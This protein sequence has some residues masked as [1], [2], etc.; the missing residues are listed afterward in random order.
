V[1]KNVLLCNEGGPK[2]TFQHQKP[3][4]QLGRSFPEHWTFQTWKLHFCFLFYPNKK[5]LQKQ[6]AIL[7]K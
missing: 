5:K 2:A 4:K 1:L 7:S 3:N 6:M